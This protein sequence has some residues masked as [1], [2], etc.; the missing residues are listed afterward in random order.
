MGY[1]WLNIASLILGLSA[2][3]A[4]TISIAKPSQKLEHLRHFQP[5]GVCRGD[6]FA[7]RLPKLLGSH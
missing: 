1:A 5:W 7:N 4:P 3:I 6:T 2:W